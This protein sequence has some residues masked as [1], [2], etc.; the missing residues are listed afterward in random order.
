MKNLSLLFNI[1]LGLAI[2]V[3][4]YLHFSNK[5]NIKAPTVTSAAASPNSGSLRIA[6]LNLDTL[7]KYITY[8]K[9]NKEKYIFLAHTYFLNI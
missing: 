3:L 5:N 8:I 6:Y 4:F 2:A 9:T 1:V 7:N